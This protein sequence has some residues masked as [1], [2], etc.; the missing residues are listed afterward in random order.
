MQLIR[1]FSLFA[2]LLVLAPVQADENAS[3]KRRTSLPTR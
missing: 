3:T 2:L 1:L